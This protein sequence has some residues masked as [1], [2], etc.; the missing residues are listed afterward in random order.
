MT[1]TLIAFLLGGVQTRWTTII[2]RFQGSGQKDL[3]FHA[4]RSKRSGLPLPYDLS[5]KFNVI[6]QDGDACI[7]P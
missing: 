5:R 7:A 2:P 1:R 3:N 6:P 4:L